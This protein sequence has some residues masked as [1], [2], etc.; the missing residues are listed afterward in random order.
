M[1]LEMDHKDFQDL[2]YHF[3]A[4]KQYRAGYVSCISLWDHF[5]RDGDVINLHPLIAPHSTSQH[6]VGFC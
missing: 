5:L 1:F 2:V 3:K 4:V 6:P